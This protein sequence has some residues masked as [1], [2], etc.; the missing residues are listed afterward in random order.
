V[1]SLR[2]ILLRAKRELVATRIVATIIRADAR[3][4][5]AELTASR[6]MVFIPVCPIGARLSVVARKY[7]ILTDSNQPRHELAAARLLPA[8]IETDPML[9]DG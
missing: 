7:S 3:W 8:E 6:C 4:L 9:T 5:N 1:T 2:A